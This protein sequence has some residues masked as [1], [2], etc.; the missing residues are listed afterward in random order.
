MPGNVSRRT[1]LRASALTA[2]QATLA[3]AAAAAV[4]AAEPAADLKPPAQAGPDP[5]AIVL[6][7]NGVERPLRVER[8]RAPWG[9]NRAISFLMRS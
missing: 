6:N 9:V 1:F 2:V 3:D 7:V 5:V 4:A 8:G